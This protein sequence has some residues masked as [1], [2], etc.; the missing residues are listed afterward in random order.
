MQWFTT[1]LLTAL[2][3]LHH[4]INV[5]GAAALLHRP[6]DNLHQDFG[7]DVLPG[8]DAAF[9]D[10]SCNLRPKL[11]RGI[12]KNVNV[13]PVPKTE[14][15]RT[16]NICL[17]IPI[18]Y[19]QLFYFLPHKHKHKKV[20]MQKWQPV[21]PS[22]EGMVNADRQRST[23]TTFRSMTADGMKGRSRTELYIHTHTHTHVQRASFH[24]PTSR[25]WLLSCWCWVSVR[26]KAVGPCKLRQVWWDENFSR[27]LLLD[28]FRA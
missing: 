8:W 9:W 16:H 3:H 28:E 22:L 2:H 5:T 15:M 18:I 12:K 23:A 17:F 10:A 1:V 11:M 26:E 19:A 13:K 20:W 21:L 4:C 6:S 7:R 25:S 24:P 14:C 27:H